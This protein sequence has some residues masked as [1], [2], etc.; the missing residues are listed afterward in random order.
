[1][2]VLMTFLILIALCLAGGFWGADSRPR[3]ID[4]ATRWWPGARD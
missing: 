1:M 2:E 4:R 3:D